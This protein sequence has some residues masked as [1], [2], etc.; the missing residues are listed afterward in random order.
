MLPAS[1]E[2][3]A[4]DVYCGLDLR[5]VEAPAL[6]ASAESKC[7]MMQSRKGRKAERAGTKESPKRAEMSSNHLRAAESETGSRSFTAPRDPHVR[8]AGHST[9]ASGGN[10]R[11]GMRREEASA[12]RSHPPSRRL[13]LRHGVR[14]T[15]PPPRKL[16]L[17][18]AHPRLLGDLL[19]DE[20]LG[21]AA[22]LRG[23]LL[24]HPRELRGHELVFLLAHHCADLL[25]DAIPVSRGGNQA[26]EESQYRPT[27]P[28]ETSE[29]ADCTWRCVPS[30][31]PRKLRSGV[32]TSAGFLSPSPATTPGCC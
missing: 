12:A 10:A 13:C 16:A 6:A 21:L 11:D 31:A 2:L 1:S 27:G 26:S 9:L 4:R 15:R 30:H 24:L 23:D 17:S 22:Q 18:A 8:A 25:V 3:P 5:R 29:A 32:H 20:R 19:L 14:W 7:S 28:A